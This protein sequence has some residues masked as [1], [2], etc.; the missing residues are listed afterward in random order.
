MVNEMEKEAPNKP[1][2]LSMKYLL[3]RIKELQHQ[4]QL[5]TERVE[6]L[7]LELNEL[8]QARIQIAAAEQF[9]IA[10]QPEQPVEEQELIIQIPRSERHRQPAPQRNSLFSRLLLI[11]KLL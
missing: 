7:E 8:G 1:P 11:T 5:L 3:E 6:R 10:G 9:E 2:K 4:N